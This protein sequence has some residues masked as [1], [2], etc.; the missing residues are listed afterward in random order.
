M[1]T[2]NSAWHHN[3]TEIT[4]IAEDWRKIDE[5]PHLLRGQL[6][7]L[8]K[9]LDHFETPDNERLHLQNLIDYLEHRAAV[10][11]SH[12]HGLTDPFVTVWDS[13]WHGSRIQ[14]AARELIEST[15]MLNGKNGEK[16][17]KQSPILTGSPA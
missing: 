15:P 7:E 1:E 6:I 3:L 17:N 14:N 16:A 12:R 2:A 10:R 13:I 11:T 4:E 8:R 9:N 5:N